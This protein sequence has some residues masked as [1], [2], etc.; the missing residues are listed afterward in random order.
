MRGAVSERRARGRLSFRRAFAVA[1]LTMVLVACQRPEQP[2]QQT[3]YVFG[4]LVDFTVLGVPEAQAAAAVAE[5]DAEFAR[6]HREWHA[7]QPG[8]ELYRLNQALAQGRALEVDDDLL[9]LVRQAQSLYAVTDGLFNAGIGALL[10]LWGFQSDEPPDGPPPTR[11]EIQALLDRHLGLDALAVDG[12]RVSSSSPAVQLDFGGFAKGVA[13]DRAIAMLR[14]RGIDNA[15]VNAG[16]DLCV[17]GRHGD[18]PW[19]IGVRHPRGQGVLASVE[20]AD[21]ECVLTSGNYE[22]FREHEGRRYAHILDP[23]TGWPVEHIVST[24]VIAGDGGFAD[25]AAT[26]LTVAGPD[27]WRSIA[28]R[29]GLTY[30]MLVDDTGTVFLTPAMAGRVRFEGEP[31]PSRVVEPLS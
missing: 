25:A 29:M 2:Y 9:P 15:I 11:D 16:G 1:A 19:R 21:G 5:V 31:P 14:A 30:V 22:R 7:W 10:A 26:A 12:H 28:A 17:A 18:R 4:T 27:D 23:R 3:A 13:L 24:T 6:M 8:G 20:A